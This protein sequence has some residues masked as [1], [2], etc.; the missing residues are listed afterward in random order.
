MNT[1]FHIAGEIELDDVDGISCIRLNPWN[2][3]FLA[4]ST[5]N[6]F[7]VIYNINS[8]TQKS[9]SNLHCPQLAVEWV[10]ANSYASAGADGIVYINDD[11]I[12]YHNSP[13]SSLAFSAKNHILA[14]G[15]YDGVVKL[16][17]TRTNQFIF[18]FSTDDKIYCMAAASPNKIVCGCLENQVFCL[19]CNTHKYEFIKTINHGYNTRQIAAYKSIIATSVVQ[20]R[21]SIVNLKD[22]KDK[23]AF[24]AHISESKGK[25]AFQMNDSS[26]TIYPVNALCFQPTTNY[27]AT[28]GTDGVVHI[29]DIENRIKRQTLNDE[30][31]EMP[32]ETSISSIS[33]SNDGN[34]LAVAV[35]YCF[36]QGPIEHP[37]DRLIIYLNR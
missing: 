4:I 23:Y 6:G 27:L 2:S 20:G 34:I 19:D 29:W 21:V 7:I 33:F 30:E 8:K 13:I 28:G 32:F 10:A 24:K 36:E 11:Q 9:R 18:E 35:S 3:E 26:K 17:N 5:W 14:S 37:P 1:Q 25:S 12:G 15:S 16:W 22:Q 31:K